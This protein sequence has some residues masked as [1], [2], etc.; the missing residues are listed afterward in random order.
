VKIGREPRGKPR[1][2]ADERDRRP[3]P[4]EAAAAQQTERQPAEPKAEQRPDQLPDLAGEEVDQRR[5]QQRHQEEDQRKTPPAGRCLARHQRNI[6]STPAIGP[7]IA[8]PSA[9]SAAIQTDPAI[10][11][12]PP[13]RRGTAWPGSVGLSGEDGR[14]GGEDGA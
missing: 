9:A 12:T 4:P 11:S 8:A 13:S 5:G 6:P 14:A 2:D 1:R 10:N 7:Q 3:L